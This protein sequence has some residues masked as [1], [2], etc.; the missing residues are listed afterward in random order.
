[1]MRIAPSEVTCLMLGLGAFPC[2]TIKTNITNISMASI[3]NYHIIANKSSAII[4][5][6]PRFKILTIIPANHK[7][8]LRQRGPSGEHRPATR[9]FGF[10]I[11]TL[12]IF[13]KQKQLLHLKTISIN[14]DTLSLSLPQSNTDTR[15]TT[16]Y[17]CGQLQ[18]FRFNLYSPR[19][20][21]VPY[22]KV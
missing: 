11:F 8:L 16:R 14:A 10:F 19:L 12:F 20:A 1:M 6:N 18:V 13:L 7:R 22:R 9:Q 21:S 15:N 4:N 5:I 2:C 3:T 17:L